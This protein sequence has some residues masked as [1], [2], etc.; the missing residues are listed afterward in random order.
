MYI[1]EFGSKDKPVIILLAPMMVSGQDLYNLM[2]PYLK[3][4]YRIISPDQGGH[5]SAEAYVS[6]DDEYQQL[7]QF[8][9][10]QGIKKIKL[11]YGAKAFRKYLPDVVTVGRKGYTDSSDN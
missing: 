4:E 9:E 6:A 2:S 8:L 7:K 3:G 11:V 1:N 5:G 10:K